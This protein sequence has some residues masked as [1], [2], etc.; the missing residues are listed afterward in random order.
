VARLAVVDTRRGQPA[1]KGAPAIQLTGVVKRYGSFTA[2]Q[3]LDL[4]VQPGE[5]FGFLGP[6]GSGKTTSIKMMTGLLEPTAGL[7]ELCGVN[8]WQAPLAAKA[9]LAYVPDEPNIFPKLT[10]WE[11]LR[12]IGSVFRMQPDVFQR[13]AEEL[14]QLFDLT[15]RAG[16]LL[17]TYS[18]GMKQK[19]AL[20]AALVHAPRVIFLDEPTVGLDP[21][22][23]RTLKAL[24]RRACDEGATVF[25]TTHIL[26]IA[27]QMCDRIGIIQAG[28]LIALG[29]IEELRRQGGDAGASLEDI[30][31]QLTG[32]QENAELIRALAVGE[33]NTLA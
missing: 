25:L 17:D 14:L 18:H 3:G 2:V 21:R 29:T 12:F 10:G 7:V 20:C 4:S 16:E 19:L 6:N 22:S 27:E 11:F 8:V 30:F 24:L 23:A 32:G 9:L 15:E 5:L 28:R 33:R 1:V 13:R 26:E 31:L